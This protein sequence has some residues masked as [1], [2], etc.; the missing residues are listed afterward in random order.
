MEFENSI[1]LRLATVFGMSPRMRTDLLVNDF[2]LR[3]TRDKF[4]VLFEGNFKRNYIHVKDVVNAFVHSL[5][6]HT[7]IEI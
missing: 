4:I 3:A 1:S 7:K 5:E 2:T 6:N